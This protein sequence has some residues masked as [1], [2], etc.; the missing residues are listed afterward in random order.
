MRFSKGIFQRKNRW[1][2]RRDFS[3]SKNNFEKKFRLYVSRKIDF[4]KLLKTILEVF[5]N[6]LYRSPIGDLFFLGGG[7]KI[8]GRQATYYE[9]KF[10]FRDSLPNIDLRLP[11][12]RS[13]FN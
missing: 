2:T 5:E 13:E 1:P 3:K 6:H 8:I 12:W 7:R 4:Q 11:F 10:L 9:S